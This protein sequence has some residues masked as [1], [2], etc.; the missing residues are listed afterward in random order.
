MFECRFEQIPDQFFFS[1]FFWHLDHTPS[2]S[3]YKAC[4]YDAGFTINSWLRCRNIL[5]GICPSIIFTSSEDAFPCYAAMQASVNDSSDNSSCLHPFVLY[6]QCVQ[7][8]VART[9]HCRQ[10]LKRKC[11]N[12]QLRVIKTIRLDME[13]V[14]LALKRYS[15]LKVVH[16]LRNPAAM[17][18]SR[19]DGDVIENPAPV[20]NRLLDDVK[21]RKVLEQTGFAGNFLAVRYEDV[22]S[23]FRL[24]ENAMAN[25]IKVK[26]A[27]HVL[28]EWQR[29]HMFSWINNNRFGTV[30]SNPASHIDKWRRNG[31]ANSIRSLLM[32]NRNCQMVNKLINYTIT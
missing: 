12:S 18:H 2:S 30:R 1:D 27:D 21:R 6:Q 3:E 22:V 14:E 15:N 25:F 24:T 28:V 9:K 11:L 16:L 17:L 7:D 26:T 19:L 31:N 13:T 10:T 32:D 4:M 8:I 20:C 5:S 29:K 23:S